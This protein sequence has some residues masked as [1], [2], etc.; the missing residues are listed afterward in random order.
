MEIQ[1]RFGYPSD[2]EGLTKIDSFFSSGHPER[3]RDISQWLKNDQ[4]FVAIKKDRLVAYAVLGDF[5]FRRPTAEMLMVVEDCRGQGV[6][7][8][9]M[10]YLEEQVVGPEIWITTNL[11][12]QPMQRLLASAGFKLTGFIDNLDPGDPELVYFK[13]LKT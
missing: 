12:N 5:F 4:L 2:F 10:R 7:R 3:A 1:I 6:G 9:L 11:S 13:K 8:Q